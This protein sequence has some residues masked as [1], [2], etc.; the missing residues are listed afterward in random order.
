MTISTKNPESALKLGIHG[1]GYDLPEEGMEE[2]EGLNEIPPEDIP[3]D[4][5]EDTGLNPRDVEMACVIDDGEK[6][7]FVA[8]AESEE[9]EYRPHFGRIILF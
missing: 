2:I 8:V 9:G 1:L 3:E 6:K 4:V 5:Y 7:Y